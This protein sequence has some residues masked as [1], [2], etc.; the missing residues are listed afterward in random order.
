[1]TRQHKLESNELLKLPKYEWF[2]YTLPF[3][4]NTLGL[5]W[6]Q[7]SIEINEIDVV[8]FIS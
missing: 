8:S 7:P 4:I 5:Q 6:I 3:A 1:M 2:E